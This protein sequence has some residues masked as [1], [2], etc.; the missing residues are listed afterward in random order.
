MSH[1]DLKKKAVNALL[2]SHF[3]KKLFYT[4]RTVRHEQVDN[5]KIDYDDVIFS[6]RYLI[7][8]F[9]QYA[10]LKGS[11]KKRLVKESLQMIIYHFKVDEWVVNFVYGGVDSVIDEIISAYNNKSY[12]SSPSRWSKLRAKLCCC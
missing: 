8:F 5:A 10:N 7:R 11:E 3:D 1:D 6:L 9:E 2:Q 12:L 4:E